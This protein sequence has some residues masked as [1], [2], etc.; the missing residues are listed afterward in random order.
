M[1]LRQR[2]SSELGAEFPYLPYV[3]AYAHTL[4]P[5]RYCSSSF[6]SRG[7]SRAHAT[8]IEQ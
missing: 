4:P 1:R 7:L 8:A 5:L 2:A 6:L 3:S